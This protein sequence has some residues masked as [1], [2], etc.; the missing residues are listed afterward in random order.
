M[1][2]FDLEQEIAWLEEEISEDECVMASSNRS[3]FHLTRLKENREKLQDMIALLRKSKAEHQ[4]LASER[5]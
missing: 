3:D 2:E 1:E 5:Q 4:A